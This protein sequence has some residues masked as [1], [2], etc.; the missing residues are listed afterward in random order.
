M[1]TSED[2]N[3]PSICSHYLLVTRQYTEKVFDLNTGEQVDFLVCSLFNL[4]IN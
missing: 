1:M 3:S 4:S 2:Y